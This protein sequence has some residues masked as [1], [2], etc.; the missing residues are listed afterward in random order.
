MMMMVVN[1]ASLAGGNLGGFGLGSLAGGGAGGAAGLGGLPGLGGLGNP[2]GGFGLGGANGIN[3]LGG[4]TGGTSNLLGVDPATL[5]VAQK[6][7]ALAAAKKQP[8]SN[9]PATNPL[10]T[11][12]FDDAFSDNTNG[13]DFANDFGNALKTELERVNQLQQDAQTAIQDYAAGGDTPV[14]QV[15]LAVNKAE[16]S[17]QLATQVRNRM[18]AAYQ[19][20]SKMQI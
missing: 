5:T 11:F 13:R 16:L 12:S 6:R 8:N 20:V 7:Q 19:D 2:A 4:L 9:N 17:L 10:A 3:G 15:M 18:V 14:H 1:I